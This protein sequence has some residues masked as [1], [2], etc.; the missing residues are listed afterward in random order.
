MSLNQKYN[1]ISSAP[2]QYLQK[3][4]DGV[5]MFLKDENVRI[6]LFGS[7]AR[8]DCVSTSDVDI[9]IIPGKEFDKVKLTLLH[10]YIEELNIPYKIDIIDLSS[11]SEEF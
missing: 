4:K 8:G 6:F 9:G 10:E 3:I 11:T 1:D 2:I 7:R 5:L